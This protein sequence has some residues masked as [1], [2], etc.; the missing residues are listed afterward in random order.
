MQTQI[1]TNAKGI[2]KLLAHY[3]GQINVMPI[4]IF[5]QG[6]ILRHAPK[7]VEVEFRNSGDVWKRETSFLDDK[8]Y[9]PGKFVVV[10]EDD[11][12]TRWN[13]A[14]DVKNVLA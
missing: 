10:V 7:G 8:Q 9:F 14:K 6:A 12:V 1:N 5:H 11:H 3:E 2:K 4:S 13:L